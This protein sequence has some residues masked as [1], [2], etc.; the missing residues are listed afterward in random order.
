PQI[1]LWQRR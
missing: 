1:T